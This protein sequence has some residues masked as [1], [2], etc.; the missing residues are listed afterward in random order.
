MSFLNS[1]NTNEGKQWTGMHMKME[2]LF[3]LGVAIEKVKNL[4]PR[5]MW[6]ILPGGVP[7]F[8]VLDGK[9]EKPI[10]DEK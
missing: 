3:A 4:L 6:P 1:C 7:Y 5:E 9:K 10:V 2:F 8:V